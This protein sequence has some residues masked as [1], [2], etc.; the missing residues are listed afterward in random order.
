M[1]QIPLRNEK[2]AIVDDEDFP[3]LARFSWSEPGEKHYHICAQFWTDDQKNT[4]IPMYKFILGSKAKSVLFKNGNL[5]DHRKENLEHVSRSHLIHKG[6][7]TMTWGGRKASSKYKGVS[8]KKGRGVWEVHIYDKTKLGNR[9]Y[10]GSFVD[11]KDAAL[12][13]NKKARELYGEYAYQNII[14]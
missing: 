14:V 5:L 10:L 2:F 3:F 7:K 11:E 9:A 4:S 12:T 13:Y 1:K 8:Y 6:K